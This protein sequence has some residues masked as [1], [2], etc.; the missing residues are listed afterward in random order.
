MYYFSC[1]LMIS[2]NIDSSLSTWI[3]FAIC[4][5]IPAS[6]FRTAFPYFLANHLA[7]Y[8]YSLFTNNARIAFNTARI[9]TPTSAK[10]ASH[11]LA[12]PTAPRIR[13]ISFTPMAT[14][15]FWYTIFRHF[16]EI[17]MAVDFKYTLDHCR[18]NSPNKAYHLIQ[19]FCSGRSQLW[20][21]SPHWKRTCWQ[22]FRREIFVCSHH[23]HW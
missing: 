6:L 21:S 20:G 18:E 12:I 4:P 5:F 8:N 16:L 13:Q 23:T 7:L 17:L 11:I 22:G 1:C 19:A 2:A 14:E 9:I 10:I 15:I 3:G